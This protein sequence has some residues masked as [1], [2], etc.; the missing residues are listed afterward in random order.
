MFELPELL[1]VVLSLLSIQDLARCTLVN[2]Q[3]YD[4][5]IPHLWH[6]TLPLWPAPWS[7]SSF[8]EIVLGDYM[9]AQSHQ[10][11]PWPKQDLF[12]SGVNA[13]RK[14]PAYQSSLSKYGPWIRNLYRPQSL[15]KELKSTKTMPGQKELLS[16]FLKHCVGARVLTLDID[17]DER[18]RFNCLHKVVADSI[19]PNLRELRLCVSSS[20]IMNSRWCLYIMSQC[21]SRLE[22]LVIWNAEE[23]YHLGHIDTDKLTV[24]TGTLCGLKELV[25]DHCWY[26]EDASSCDWFWRSCGNV[27]R[28][29]LGKGWK[30]VRTDVSLDPLACAALLKHCGTLE[31]VQV[32]NISKS[33]SSTLRHILSSSPRLQAMTT[34]DD[35]WYYQR[36]FPFLKAKDFVDMRHDSGILTPWASLKVLKTKI[37][38]IPRPDVTELL[39][40]RQRIGFSPESQIQHVQQRVY[41]RLARFINLEELFLGHGTM[42]YQYECLEMTLESGLAQLK[43]LKNLGVLDVQMMAQR[44]GLKEVQWMTQ[45]WPKLQVIQGLHDDGDNFKAAEWLWKHSPMITV[46]VSSRASIAR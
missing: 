33:S 3:W 2:K 46:K 22:K 21:S 27:K 32:T 10:E 38:C 18:D 44:I 36:Q 29:E 1:D 20:S 34:T 5:T 43:R 12:K 9:Q 7:K 35:R 24:A 11:H 39:D 15:F 23:S 6:T 28:L 40:G 30:N 4:A 14:V 19:A 8:Q 31:T 45:N 42:D 13:G 17:W 41:E 37:T 25:V 26:K 16:H